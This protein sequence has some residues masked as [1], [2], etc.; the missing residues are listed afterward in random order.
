MPSHAEQLK[1]AHALKLLR[2]L[3]N[4]AHPKTTGG[5]ILADNNFNVERVYP[6]IVTAIKSCKS[7]LRSSKKGVDLDLRARNEQIT[8]DKVREAIG[9]NA[10][11]SR[12]HV[13]VGGKPNGTKQKAYYGNPDIQITVGWLWYRRVYKE[14]YEP[15]DYLGSPLVRSRWFILSAKEVKVNDKLVR[16]FRAVGYNR[17]TDETKDI[18]IGKSKSGN[19]HAAIA[20][21][22]PAAVSAARTLIH[23][24]MKARI[25]GNE[26]DQ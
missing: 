7:R 11:R 20:F 6:T 8:T 14:F 15:E 22:V 4:A 21:T 18:F 13:T 19:R 17:K 2:Q 23:K 12:V 16:L 24:D 1:A 25:T 9:A 26:N 3:A 5:A 10:M